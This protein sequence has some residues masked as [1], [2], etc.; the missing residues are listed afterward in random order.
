MH[1]LKRKQVDFKN[2]PPDKNQL[3]LSIT[4][5]ILPYEKFKGSFGVQ[6]W[7]KDGTSHHFKWVCFVSFLCKNRQSLFVVRPS[8]STSTFSWNF[9]G[10]NYR[11]D[12]PQVLLKEQAANFLWNR[13]YF[14]VS[15]RFK[16]HLFYFNLILTPWFPK[17]RLTH[18][19]CHVHL[20][21]GND[22][23][24]FTL[25]G[26]NF[27]ILLMQHVII[28]YLCRTHRHIFSVSEKKATGILNY[29]MII[30]GV[31]FSWRL[32]NSFQYDK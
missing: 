24:T 32:R 11:E 9:S 10:Q 6:G 29:W 28:T 18:Q 17:N 30:V 1:W 20:D 4:N 7:C 31:C 16:C 15:K 8:A 14:T 27:P 25:D 19:E 23:Y 3:C 22:I 5:W 21:S 2:F 12:K 13:E 26:I